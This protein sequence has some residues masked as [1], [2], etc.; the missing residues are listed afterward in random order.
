M[1]VTAVISPSG[2]GQ[3]PCDTKPGI[4]LKHMTEM[5]AVGRGVTEKMSAEINLQCEA[6]EANL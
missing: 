2:Y 1:I 6:R 3:G 4:V 5:D